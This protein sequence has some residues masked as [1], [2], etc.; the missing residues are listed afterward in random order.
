MEKQCQQKRREDDETFR[1]KVA[2]AD[3][4]ALNRAML[5]L[6]KNEMAQDSR[7]LSAAFEALTKKLAAEADLTA[8]QRKK[9]AL[10]F[11]QMQKRFLVMDGVPSKDI[12]AN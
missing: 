8:T 11:L 3:A 10:S 9:R 5:K 12:P 4:K 2:A 6:R 1:K 7:A